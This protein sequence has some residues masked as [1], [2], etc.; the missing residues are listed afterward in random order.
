MV[1]ATVVREDLVQ[2]DFQ[3]EGT[4]GVKMDWGLPAEKR[5]QQML[6]THNRYGELH[7]ADL[8]KA[9]YVYI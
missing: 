9:T 3:L 7:G 8:E 2:L 6:S 4:E 5:R 1:L